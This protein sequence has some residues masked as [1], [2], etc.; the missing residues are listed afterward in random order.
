MTEQRSRDRATFTCDVIASMIPI[1]AWRDLPMY[2][3]F[4]CGAVALS[5]S[6]KHTDTVVRTLRGSK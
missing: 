3:R 5:A 2:I 6:I 1:W 4:N